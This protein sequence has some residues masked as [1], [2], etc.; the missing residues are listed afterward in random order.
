[1]HRAKFCLY[2]HFHCKGSLHTAHSHALLSF[3]HPF[4]PCCS[5]NLYLQSGQLNKSVKINSQINSPTCCGYRENRLNVPPY[6]S[7]TLNDVTDSYDFV[8]LVFCLMPPDHSYHNS[9]YLHPPQPDPVCIASSV[10]CFTSL[11]TLTVGTADSHK[12]LMPRIIRH[13]QHRHKECS[14]VADWLQLELH[15]MVNFSFLCLTDIAIGFT[16]I[17]RIP[18]FMTLVGSRTQQTCFPTS[19]GQDQKVR[20]SVQHLSTSVYCSFL[21]I[22]PFN[23]KI[24]L[25]NPVAVLCCI[26][27]TVFLI[28]LQ[29]TV[30]AY[31]S[32]VI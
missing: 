6:A 26:V 4:S 24:A 18:I 17:F 5:P 9:Y 7:M 3:N 15:D 8:L 27:K 23:E 19:G 14:L 13:K 28:R 11:Y 16:I 29:I 25:S 31:C 32:P 10:C 30:Q 21:H 12:R 2:A 22:F 20:T 1:M